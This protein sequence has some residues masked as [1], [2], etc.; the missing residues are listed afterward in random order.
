M[1]LRTRVVALIGIVLLTG[2][3]LGSLFAG[4]Q[5]RRGLAEELSA[6]MAGARQTVASSFED[7]ARS[8]H[9]GRDLRQLTATFDGN[10]HVRALLIGADGRVSMT[11]TVTPPRAPAPQW[12]E[13]LLGPT[14]AP[15]HIA[16]PNRL[17]GYTELRLEATPALDVSAL[18][19]EFSGVVLLLS[20]SS[21]LGLA[22]VYFAIGAALR[23]LHDLSAGFVRI[24]AGDYGGRVAERGPSELRSLEQ[25]FNAMS[26]ELAAMDD[27]NRLLETQLVTLQDEERADLAR[28][29]HDEIGPHLFAVNV[30]AQVIGGLV[31][32]DRAEDIRAHVKS[33][34]SGV[35]HMQRLVREILSRLRPTRATELGLNAAIGDLAAF[36]QARRPEMSITLN[37]PKTESGLNEA[38]KDTLYRVVQEGLANAVRH[39]G[40]A[41]VEVSLA[42]TGGEAMVRVKDDGAGVSLGPDVTANVAGGLGLIGMRER[43]RASSGVL[44]IDRG[45]G[46]WEVTAR[47]PL[48]VSRAEMAS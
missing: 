25:G 35:G 24:G 31:G 7:L 3:L 34:Q 46:G 47:L 4:L 12:F 10:R 18:W 44:A 27:R 39:G 15:V 48:Q 21:M 1:S 2:V 8:D 14:P 23:P 22:L 26:A 11:S 43:V 40:A 29:L 19:N 36:W 28:D 37:L 16:V 42:L 5:A 17:G 38:L 32:T 9:P 33:I 13:H 20:A 41:Q 30:D 45:D 6:G